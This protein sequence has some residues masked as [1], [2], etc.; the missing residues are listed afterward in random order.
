V[1]GS[2]QYVN[3]FFKRY[4]DVAK[5]MESHPLFDYLRMQKLQHLLQLRNYFECKMK[6]AIMPNEESRE[7]WR[8]DI[9]QFLEPEYRNQIGD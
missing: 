2:E 4:E 1:D 9:K 5:Q 7:K 8:K 6:L 3:K